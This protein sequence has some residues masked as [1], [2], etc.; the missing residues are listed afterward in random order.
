MRKGVVRGAASGLDGEGFSIPA[1]EGSEA[2]RSEG[3]SKGRRKKR[4]EG[5]GP[6]A[7]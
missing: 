5:E 4:E 3:R 7:G 2:D 1:G 6:G